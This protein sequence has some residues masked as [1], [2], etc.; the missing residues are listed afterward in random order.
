VL[1]VEAGWPAMGAELTT[2]TIPAEAG[3]VGLAVS[4]TKGCYTGQELVARI[5]SRGGNVPRH[6]RGLVSPVP[7]EVGA[8]LHDAAG[9]TVGV[10]SSVALSATLGPVG[11]GVVHRSVAPPATLAGGVEVRTLPLVG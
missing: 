8:E 6:V 4:F 5:D 9:A 7:L 11:L 1:R 10:V 3:V 2:D